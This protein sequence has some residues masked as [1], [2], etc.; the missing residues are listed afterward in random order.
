MPDA[1]WYERH[2]QACMCIHRM[3]C[4]LLMEEVDRT[5]AQAGNTMIFA[6]NDGCTELQLWGGGMVHRKGFLWT[7]PSA[8]AAAAAIFVP[9]GGCCRASCRSFSKPLML[10]LFPS[11]F[12]QNCNCLWYRYDI[13]GFRSWRNPLSPTSACCQLH[14]LR[15]S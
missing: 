10:V 14:A 5:A 9:R 3:A 12:S 11:S 13:S 2:L 7:K 15:G 6:G 8:C 4:N 1:L